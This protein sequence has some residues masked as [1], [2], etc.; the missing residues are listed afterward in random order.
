MTFKMPTMQ[1][2][3][4]QNEDVLREG[5]QPKMFLY[6]LDELFFIFDQVKQ[7]R[8]IDERFIM[9]YKILCLMAL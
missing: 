1:C 2:G 7:Q 3:T 4:L 8:G 9:A 5:Y 6:A